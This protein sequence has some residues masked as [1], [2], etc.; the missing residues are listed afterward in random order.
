MVMTKV[1]DKGNGGQ[2]DTVKPRTPH[3]Y[4]RIGPSEIPK[5]V[6]KCLGSTNPTCRPYKHTFLEGGYM[7]R[8]LTFLI[9]N[10]IVEHVKEKH[11][12]P[13]SFACL[14]WF[15]TTNSLKIVTL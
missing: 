10:E 13:A 11:F 5:L 2:G 14:T 15:V 6:S 4:S 8:Q 3:E 1:T 9:R 12:K 7:S